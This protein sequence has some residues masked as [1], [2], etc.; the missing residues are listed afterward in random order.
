MKKPY[1]KPAIIHTQ[2]MEVRA[3]SCLKNDPSPDGP[4]ASGIVT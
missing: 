3:V 2:K 4:C 1:E